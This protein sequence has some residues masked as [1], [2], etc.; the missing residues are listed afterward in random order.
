MNDIQFF[1]H[2][3]MD[4]TMSHVHATDRSGTRGMTPVLLV[5]FGTL[6]FLTPAAMHI[7][8]S[9]IGR[10]EPTFTRVDYLLNEAGTSGF[11]FTLLCMFVLVLAVSLICRKVH[12]RA[13]SGHSMDRWSTMATTLAR[14][15]GSV[16]L[17]SVAVSIA[18]LTL[19]YGGTARG[20]LPSENDSEDQ[21]TT[22]G[23]LFLMCISAV[24]FIGGIVAVILNPAGGLKKTKYTTKDGE[25]NDVDKE[26]VADDVMP[27]FSAAAAGVAAI[28]AFIA[29]YNSASDGADDERFV[30]SIELTESPAEST[31][32]GIV[33][34]LLVFGAIFGLWN[35]KADYGGKV[36]WGRS[37]RGLGELF[38]VAS[39]LHTLLSYGFFIARAV[40]VA[41]VA[42]L[43]ASWGWVIGYPALA[44]AAL[45][46]A[47]R[48]RYST[49][50]DV[51][52]VDTLYGRMAM[53]TV[54]TALIFGVGIVVPTAG[55]VDHVAF[56]DSMGAVGATLS[57]IVLSALFSYAHGG[58]NW[59]MT[60]LRSTFGAIVGVIVTFGLILGIGHVHRA[61]YDD[62]DFAEDRIVYTPFILV[63]G[64]VASSISVLVSSIARYGREA[65][66][67]HVDRASAAAFRT[68]SV[69]T[70]G[71]FLT[72]FAV[73]LPYG[74][75]A[76]A[77]V[78]LSAN[79]Y[80]EAQALTAPV[81]SVLPRLCDEQPM[82]ANETVALEQLIASSLSEAGGER[83]LLRV[84]I[85]SSQT[86]LWLAI[87]LPGISYA[88]S[89][90]GKDKSPQARNDLLFGTA[91]IAS[92]SIISG[93]HGHTSPGEG[94]LT[95][96][97]AHLVVFAVIWWRSRHPSGENARSPTILLIAL[98]TIAAVFALV[99]VDVETDDS[100]CTVG[101]IAPGLNRA[102][103]R[104]LSRAWAYPVC[105]HRLRDAADAE[106]A[107][108]DAMR[109][110][111][112]AKGS[113]AS[114]RAT[115]LMVVIGAGLIL[116]IAVVQT[117][118][119]T[120]LRIYGDDFHTPL[121][122][123]T[124]ADDVTLTDDESQTALQSGDDEA[125][126]MHSRYSG[127][128]A[129]LHL[130]IAALAL[131]SFTWVFDPRATGT[132]SKTF[133]LGLEVGTVLFAGLGI[134]L[135]A[136]VSA[137]MVYYRHKDNY[138]H[139]TTELD[140]PLATLGA[141]AI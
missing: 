101:L 97:A 126:V 73:A 37:F 17:G 81:M 86:L 51:K 92:L 16:M 96:M 123:D 54:A 106:Y 36:A 67:P 84:L 118:T 22:G 56:R 111:C 99:T 127:D 113:E 25:G 14:G 6:L 43:P 58:S 35:R 105:K 109:V 116:V 93:L 89:N 131:L 63:V 100:V 139:K 59:W 28:A 136:Y 64:L 61:G 119:S 42:S 91:A 39:A 32:F 29:F 20:G 120:Y 78:E 5:V 79:D 107:V 135:V 114:E 77:Y 24:L 83:L 124:D 21:M 15:G 121:V 48:T 34:A 141:S 66:E 98:I 23:L 108:S 102:S 137:R 33:S 44:F 72:T 52:A 68:I 80:A 19:I 40:S 57:F 10:P 1:T 82:L 8:I 85:H 138:A 128:L 74:H 46:V 132:Y 103:A 26:E 70:V 130:G 115:R 50:K 112:D 140:V 30:P 110:V 62:Y 27:V 7:H 3:T 104:E 38:A 60:T 94:L 2:Y 133:N 13:K 76:G 90:S 134:L 87:V 12:V 4:D 9:S 95:K 125:R 11:P 75:T 47:Y 55:S 45:L 65:S 31:Q 49:N 88:L 69:I 41:Q 117:W 129:A 18:F 122:G 53:Y 71:L